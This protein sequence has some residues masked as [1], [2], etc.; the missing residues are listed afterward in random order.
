MGLLVIRKKKGW[1]VGIDGAPVRC[2]TLVAGVRTL[3]VRVNVCG[4]VFV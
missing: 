2:N 4:F 1:V 3:W